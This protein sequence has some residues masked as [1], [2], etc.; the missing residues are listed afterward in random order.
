M[1]ASFS[2]ACRKRSDQLALAMPSLGNQPTLVC[3]STTA[4]SVQN[5]M[6]TIW[7]ASICTNPTPYQ[8]YI[9]TTSLI[10][11]ATTSP[12]MHQQI[13]QRHA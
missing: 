6:A 9:P 7:D 12:C 1:K 5:Q 8:E 2:W 13:L 11:L 3:P 10:D 4:N